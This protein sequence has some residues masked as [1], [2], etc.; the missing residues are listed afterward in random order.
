MREFYRRAGLVVGMAAF[1]WCFFLADGTVFVALGLPRETTSRSVPL[2]LRVHGPATV[3]TL[4]VSGPHWQRFLTE[5][6][7]FC[8]AAPGA[9][10]WE[11]RLAAGA[12]R[13]DDGP[14][15]VYFRG[16]EAPV[17][18]LVG[19]LSTKSPVR[20]VDETGTPALLEARLVRL[21]DS[22]FHLGM[23]LSNY[24]AP[25][26][27]IYIW[28]PLGW[29]CLIFGAVFYLAI[30]RVRRPA[31]ALGYAGWRV[32]LSD[33]L[34]IMLFPVFFGLPLAI[35]GGSVQAVTVYPALLLM[36]WPLAALSALLVWYAAFCASFCLYC[37][38]AGLHVAALSTRLAIPYAAISS[39][40]RVVHASPR[41]LTRLL[42]LASLFGTGAQRAH[43]AGQA[44]L[45]E[46]ARAGGLALELHDGRTVYLW[47]TDAW[48]S[49][50]MPGAAGIEQTLKAAGVLCRRPPEKLV[51][52][53][54]PLCLT[55]PRTGVGNGR[56]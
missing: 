16:D 56:R 33:V 20:L 12:R 14:R 25:K 28:R 35:A 50:A 41:W 36:F 52:F 44:L 30:P 10:P 29:A 42:W 18:S 31:G 8:T 6:H 45:L 37:D 43:T 39:C 11:K 47:L 24:G 9:P 22:D 26:D 49:P 17:A 48:G 19:E 1:L 38:A 54:P 53:F 34:W 51:A 23:G 55:R 5:V 13:S 3:T 27:M 46:H 7:A 4:P 2:A 32:G 40:R 21:T 15:T